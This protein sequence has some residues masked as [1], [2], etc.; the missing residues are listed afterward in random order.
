M[1]SLFY[2]EPGPEGLQGLR[3]GLLEKVLHP[4]S[5][6]AVDEAAGSTAGW[7]GGLTFALALPGG[8]ELGRWLLPPL[9]AASCDLETQSC[10]G[11]GGGQKCIVTWVVYEPLILFNTF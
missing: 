4:D 8:F 7:A 9:A 3:V 2:L 1:N 5:A 10:G 11:G 6:A